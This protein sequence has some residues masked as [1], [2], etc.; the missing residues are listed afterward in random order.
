MNNLDITPQ[1]ALAAA[2]VLM[3][4]CRQNKTGDGCVFGYRP[5]CAGLPE[6][7]NLPERDDDE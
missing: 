1:M 7:W 5:N 4:Y 6:N 3:D 2:R